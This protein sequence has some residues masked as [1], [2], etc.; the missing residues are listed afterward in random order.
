MLLRLAT[1]LVTVGFVATSAPQASGQKIAPVERPGDGRPVCGLGAEFHAGRRAELRK[2]VGAGVILV[3]GLPGTRGYSSFRQ[4]KTFWYLTGVESPNANLLMD[5]ESGREILF[6]PRKN[7]YTE[8]YEGDVWDAEDPWVSAL[9]GFEEVRSNAELLPLLSELA[10]GTDQVWISTHPWSVMKG[11]ADRARPVDQW[12]E[13]DPLD[14]RPSREAALRRRLS[15]LLPDHAVEPMDVEL[16]DMRRVKTAE[17][18]EALWRAGL[19]G[20]R[21]MIEGIRATR[22]GLG[23]WELEA[24][25]SF[26]QV[27]EGAAGPAYYGIVASGPGTVILHYDAAARKMKAGELVLVDYGCELDHYTTDITRTWPV[28]GAF[29]EEQARLYDIVLEAQ[30]AGIA[31]VRPG[32]G[33]ADVERAVTAV[34]EQHGVQPLKKHGSCHFVGLEVHDAGRLN[35]PLE[36]GV[37][38]TI[39]PGLYDHENSMGVRIEDVVVVTADGCEVLT[40]A[41]PK[42]RAEI[43]A[44]VGEAGMLDRVDGVQRD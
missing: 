25:M 6:L 1:A 12:I 16:A 7:Y 40:A 32:A 17:E 4:D 41:V 33:I 30:E 23:E 28:D 18:I 9:T 42:A 8:Q 43:E 14:G 13:Q 39:E 27:R 29:T 37:V 38:F 24:L 34:F 5:A 36:P 3:R 21:A 15:E 11:S 26:V 31:A 20:A 10:E 19:A 22:E 44:L 2:R 35:A